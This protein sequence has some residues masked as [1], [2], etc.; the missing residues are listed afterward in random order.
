MPATSPCRGK[1]AGRVP[2]R[3]R[4]GPR[5]G[6]VPGGSLRL[7]SW[8]ACA[9][10]V[11]RVS[12]RSL[13]RP[14][15]RTV[16]LA[17]GDSAGAPGLFRVDADT[18]PFGLED[19]TPGSRACVRVRALLGRIGRA[20]LLGTFW[21]AS[22]FLWCA[23]C[24][25]GPLRA[26]VAPFVVVVGFFFF[27]FPFPPSRCA[28]VG[29]LLCVFSGPGCLGPWR[30]APPPLFPLPPPLCAPVVSCS[31]CFPASGALG[32]CLLPPPP[33]FFAPPVVSGVS[34]FPVALGLFRPP[35]FFLPVVRCWAGLCVLGRQVCP[36]VPRWC[37]PCR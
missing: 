2:R 1:G 19:A 26:E 12:T 10:V 32:L 22:P 20:G 23:L 24:L 17:T 36:R 25:F 11:R 7:H 8:A 28:P 14:V 13:M 15:S 21:C 4:L 3:T 9:A 33:C 5:N 37:C 6:V 31:A 29:V 27:P 16:R 30:P 35:P 34:C 18:G